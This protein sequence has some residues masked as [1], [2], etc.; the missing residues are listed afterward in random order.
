MVNIC[1]WSIQNKLVN[2][3]TNDTNLGRILKEP[4][5][6]HELALKRRA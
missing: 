1:S 6:A 4:R 3:D 2:K 5:L